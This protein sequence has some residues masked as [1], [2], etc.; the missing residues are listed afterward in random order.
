MRESQRGVKLEK[1]LT[2][3]TVSPGLA[4]GAAVKAEVEVHLHAVPVPTLDPL[5]PSHLR[6]EALPKNN[7]DLTKDF[8]DFRGMVPDTIRSA[9]IWIQEG[10]NQLTKKK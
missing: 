4:L 8:S 5:L 9:D 3:G 7:L 2:A 1:I 10:K 6:R